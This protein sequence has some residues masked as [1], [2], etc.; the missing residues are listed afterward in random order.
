MKRKLLT[1]TALLAAF[2]AQSQCFEYDCSDAANNVDVEDG[3]SNYDGSTCFIGTGSIP[4]SCNINNWS[5]ISVYGEI[6]YLQNINFGSVGTKLISKGNNT[7]AY[8]SMDGSD[9]VYVKSGICEVSTI[10]SNNSFT[11]QFNT[12]VVDDGAEFYYGGIRLDPTL[13]DVTVMTAG[14]TGNVIKIIRGCEDTPL[15]ISASFKAKTY[16]C[17]NFVLEWDKNVYK[18]VFVERKDRADWR[19]QE[20]VNTG[21]LQGQLD[22][23]TYFRLRINDQYTDIKYLTPCNTMVTIYPNPTYNYINVKADEKILNITVSDWTMRKLITTTDENISLAHLASG[24]Y[25]ITVITES[26]IKTEKIVLIK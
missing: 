13:S 4:T 23:P 8:L 26:E 16:Y 5:V 25:Y 11:G 9:T 6:N 24:T 2:T 12:I 17:N 22:R 7:F 10:I 3:T 20:A 1:L 21:Y 14:G 15:P 19:I 18:T